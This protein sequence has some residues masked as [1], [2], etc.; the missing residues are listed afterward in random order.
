MKKKWIIIA[1]ATLAC[2]RPVL[3]ILGL[4]DIVFDPQNFEEA[5][6][7]LAQLQQ[8][9][10]QLVQTYHM[11]ESQYQQMVWMAKQDPVNMIL[12][13]RP[14]ASPWLPSTASNTYGTTAAWTAGINTG[15]NVSAG[16]SGATERL[17]AYG[18][19]FD[20]IPSDQADRMKTGYASVELTDGA[21]LSGI[22]TIGEIRG[23]ANAVETAIQ[24][25]EEDSLSSDPNMNTQ[26]AVLNKI[27]AAN[28]IGL[29]NTQD[30]NKLLAAL[31]EEQILQAKRV[32]DAET[33]A[34]NQDIQFRSQAKSVMAEQAAN[35][36]S[37]MLAWRM[38]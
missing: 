10:A 6:Q 1:V 37:A 28:V 11:I 23:N 34:I 27:N 24:N 31:A 4:G 35:A 33:D 14:I 29:R 19:A 26:I 20:N 22:Q 2:V 5:V 13:Y 3:A 9:Y 32:R 21:N 12:R 8:Q 17:S 25:L 30:T 36:S 18:S 38:P 16:Y 7:E 15:Q